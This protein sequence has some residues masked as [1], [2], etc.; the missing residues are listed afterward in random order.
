MLRDFQGSL[1]WRPIRPHA[2][3]QQLSLADVAVTLAIAK[4]VAMQV[5]EEWQDIRWLGMVALVST[6]CLS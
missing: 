2:I 4:V 6:R 5:T 1:S 3:A